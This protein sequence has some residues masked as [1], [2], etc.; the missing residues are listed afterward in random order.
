MSGAVAAP[1]EFVIPSSETTQSLADA[2]GVSGPVSP[3]R[4][5]RYWAAYDEMT[6]EELIDVLMSVMPAGVA[7]D[8]LYEIGVRQGR[9]DFGG[10]ARTGA[11]S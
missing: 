1:V 6:T 3:I 7:P 10:P 9:G 11:K 8:L 5:P 2:P 4:M